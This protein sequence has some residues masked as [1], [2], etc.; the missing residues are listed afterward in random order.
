M[1]GRP[2]GMEPLFPR[3]DP[4][5]FRFAYFAYAP[6]VDCRHHLPYP[7][8]EMG[9][10]LVA[11]VL[12]PVFGL[13]GQLNLIA[14]GV[15][16]CVL[17]SVGIASLVVGLR[18]RLWAHVLLAAAIW[19]IMA[20]AT[21]FDVFASPFEEPAALVG[22]LLVSAGLVYLGRG[23]R[24]AIVG[25]FLAGSGGFLAILSKEQYLISL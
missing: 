17:A 24:L 12:T 22:L 13:R 3:G 10:L 19:V 25:L 18:V 4:R 1:C 16:M 15:L 5:Y 2:L 11:R 6:S 9:P 23:K 14:L 7:T 20:D 21:F 8:S